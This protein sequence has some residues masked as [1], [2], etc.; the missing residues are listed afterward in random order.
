MEA[1]MAVEFGVSSYG[2][3]DRLPEDLQDRP[4]RSAKLVASLSWSWSPAHSRSNN[5]W[6]CT[7]RQ[8]S[9]WILWEESSDWETGKPLYFRVAY[10]EPWRGV[11]AKRAA[12]ELLEA[13]WLDEHRAW[14]SPG[15]GAWVDRAGLLDRDDIERIE[16]RVYRETD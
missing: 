11:D 3:L 8:R 15:R 1:Q 10:G 5:Y 2:G 7:N 12:E 4:P 16:E 13:A 6:L 9:G 14:E